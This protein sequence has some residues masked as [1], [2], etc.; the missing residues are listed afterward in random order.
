MRSSFALA[1]A[2]LD[3]AIRNGTLPPEGRAMIESTSPSRTFAPKKTLAWDGRWTA[4]ALVGSLLA[5]GCAGSAVPATG[6]RASAVGEA[7]TPPEPTKPP[8]PLASQEDE[9]PRVTSVSAVAPDVLRVAVET[10][11][12]ERHGQENYERK[13]GDHVAGKWRHVVRDGKPLGY[14]V[15]DDTVMRWEEVKL[16]P[17]DESSWDERGNIFLDSADDMR[18]T[19]PITPTAVYR[20]SR[21]KVVASVGEWEFA[22]PTEHVYY[23][24]LPR[25][26]TPGRTYRLS[27]R[28]DAQSS[29]QIPVF[30]YAPS[31]HE[32]EAVHVTQL[33]FRPDDP[34]KV[35]FLS[36]WMGSGGALRYPDGSRFSVVEIG[37][38]AKVYE[39]VL[40]QTLNPEA[41]EDQARNHTH[42]FVYQ[43]D[44]S[45]LEKPGKY[46]L[47]VQGVG[48]SR[49]FEIGKDV[50]R[51]AFRSAARGFYHQRRSIRLGPPHTTYEKPADPA[52]FK[53]YQSTTTLMETGNGIYLG[54]KDNF[55]D[56]VK[57]QTAKVCAECWGGLMDAGDWDSRVQHLIATTDLIELVEFN[58]TFFTGLDLGIPESGGPLP[59]ALDEALYNLDHYRRMQLPSGAIRGG[60]EY[61]EH[62]LGGETSYQTSMRAFV[63]APDLWSSYLYAAAAAR[64]ASLLASVEPSLAPVYRKSAEKAMRWAEGEWARGNFRRVIEE[65]LQFKVHDARNYAAAALH[66]LT[67]DAGWHNIFRE[68]TQFRTPQP[69]LDRWGHFDQGEACWLYLDQKH[70]VDSTIGTN[71]RK[72]LLSQADSH[73]ERTGQTGFRWAVEDG[74]WLGYGAL[75]SPAGKEMIRAHRLTGKKEYLSG[76][77]LSAQLGLG[78]NPLNLSY[79]FGVGH[80]NPIRAL[81]HDAYRSGQAYPEGL[82][83]AGPVDL[84]KYPSPTY[85][86]IF[87]GSIYP[88]VEGWPTLECFWNM[89]WFAIMTEFTIHE[90]MTDVAYVW[91]YLAAR[92]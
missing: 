12:A 78:A 18:M 80:E 79:T 81:H 71:C 6:S 59:D 61:E 49:D 75:T 86:N 77:I 63:Y 16:G 24:K 50:W 25:S 60:V 38:E 70:E 51:K 21:P 41:R 65:K 29:S 37:S 32:S 55:S 10:G 57:G 4:A 19:S 66:R 67:G 5:A 23:L 30:T 14:L 48:C 13:P 7:S 27:L 91:G 69:R 89:T 34:T 72:A 9:W 44:F 17:F 54:K 82:T 33:G 90:P 1:H 64:A 20:K 11:T 22:I 47:C 15:G 45:P 36:V 74:V 73:Y 92:E 62:P 31:R 84:Q 28:D 26:L 43:A 46:R 56:L 3:D 85:M 76:A 53:V 68:T 2:M 58:P 39:G 8:S 35:G 52:T 87:R 42:T 40:K 88:E 83:L